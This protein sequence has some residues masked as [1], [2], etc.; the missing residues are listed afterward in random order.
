MPLLLPANYP[1]HPIDGYPCVQGITG[2]KESS[3][4]NQI[5][6][7][8]FNI[9][10]QAEQYERLILNRLAKSS[11]LIEPVF[12]KS[13]MHL[14]QSSCK[15]HLEKFYSPFGP[16]LYD[17][18][19]AL[20]LTGAPVEKMPIDQIRYW[21]E[22]E[23]L[24]ALSV[25]KSIPLLGICWGGMALGN[26]LG[27]KSQLYP[28]KIFGVYNAINQKPDC[29]IMHHM[30][31]NFYCPQSRYA[32]LDEDDLA[33]FEQ[34]GVINR[35]AWSGATGTFLFETTDK[36]L[37]GHLGHPEYLPERLVFEWRRDQ[38]LGLN[39]PAYGFDPHN[40]MDNWSG[41]SQ[42]FFENWLGRIQSNS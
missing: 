2:R 5:R 17:Q 28:K 35:L 15:A 10:P 6:V 36:L 26:V 4:N 20:I 1:L 24:V 13:S 7:G 27:I 31:N 32:G 25:R 40:P 14:Y 34:Q 37:T 9:M 39:T 23:Q 29:E 22:I 30:P 18:V 42:Q 38:R 11:I 3:I 33:G 12:I 19:D 21:A 8:V 41:A 16:F